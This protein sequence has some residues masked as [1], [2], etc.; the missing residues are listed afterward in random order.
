VR[1]IS[2]PKFSET[3]EIVLVNTS[4]LE[5]EVIKF[6]AGTMETELK[7]ETTNGNGENVM[8]DIEEL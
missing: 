1:I 6:S 5:T 3:S 8:D 2:I 7:P 4:T